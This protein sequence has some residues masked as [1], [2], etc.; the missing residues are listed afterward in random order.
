MTD[1]H[2]RA[3]A[4]LSAAFPTQRELRAI[5]RELKP[6][7]RSRAITC[8]HCEILWR[9]RQGETVTL[10]RLAAIWPVISEGLWAQYIT[11]LQ[12]WGVLSIA[13]PV[14]RMSEDT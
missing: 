13:A 5:E 10:E 11:Q 1:Q 8:M 7:A 3:D 12:S 4:F 2:T 9:V 6:L 14:L